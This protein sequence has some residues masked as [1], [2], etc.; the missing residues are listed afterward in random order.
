M[1]A[2]DVPSGLRNYPVQLAGQGAALQLTTLSMRDRATQDQNTTKAYI[3]SISGEV[4]G[5]KTRITD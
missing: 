2:A 1:P 4:S 5:C 3:V